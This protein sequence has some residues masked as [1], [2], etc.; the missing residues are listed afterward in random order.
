[1]I[2]LLY[3]L[4]ETSEGKLIDNEDMLLV[5]ALK[6]LLSVQCYCLLMSWSG[7]SFCVSVTQAIHSFE[8]ESEKELSLS[9]GDYVV[10]RK[11]V[12]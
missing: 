7:L 9:V 3:Y 11:V 2:Y 4:K 10:V 8:A 6:T 5:W 1:M 12:L